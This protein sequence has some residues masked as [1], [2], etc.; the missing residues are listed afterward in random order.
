ML[1]SSSH[2]PPPGSLGT[3][4]DSSYV[5][6]GVRILQWREKMVARRWRLVRLTKAI[7]VTIDDDNSKR[8]EEDEHVNGATM[9]TPLR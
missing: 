2:P 1:S 5:Q 4:P 8:Q 3:E 6:Q 7:S 9:C